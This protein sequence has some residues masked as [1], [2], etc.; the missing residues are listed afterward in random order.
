MAR[1]DAARR[2]MAAVA[3][4][5]HGVVSFA[6]LRACGFT[7][8]GVR[9]LVRRGELRRCHRGVY[10]LGP[11]LGPGAREMAA[12][13]ACGSG[14]VASHRSA[15]Y[16]YAILP[17]PAQPG[18][19][20]VTVPGRHLSGN[21]QIVVHQTVSL[22]PHEIR[23]RDGIPVTAPIRALMDLA[24][25]CDDSELEAAV[26]EAFALRL[27]NRATLLRATRTAPGRRGAARL[28]E[29][30]DGAC[31]P[32]HTRSRPERKLLA[33][34]RAA[35]LPDPET[36]VKLGGWEVD[37]LWPEARL[38]VEVDAYSTHSSP[39]AFE[40]DRRKDADSRHSD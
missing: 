37:F 11:L 29:L 35:G 10:L 17:R 23:E 6:Q 38:V 13:L 5:Q 16:L 2:R 15:A 31:R 27:V 22:R 7:I 24:G 12:V 20:Q 40:R 25:C 32:K 26:A 21:A 28:T 33:A 36:N 34:I 14:A 30:L 19:V 18:R 3:R 1:F 8:D 9:G 39:R 4:R